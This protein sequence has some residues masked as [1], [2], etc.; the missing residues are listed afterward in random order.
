MANPIIYNRDEAGFVRHGGRIGRFEVD[1]YKYGALGEPQWFTV[2]H[3]AGARAD[4]KE[5]A[6][7]LNRAYQE[8]HVTSPTRQWGDIAYHFMMDDHGRYYRA[9]YRDAKGA[10]VSEE[11]SRNFGLMV[12]GN[13][14]THELTTAQKESLRW[15]YRGGLLVLTGEPEAG[16]KGIRTHGDW[17]ATGCPGRNLQRYMDWLRAVET[18]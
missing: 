12:H 18:L 5:T 11:N 16:F 2:H 6:V 4:D 14:D 3:A 9:R 8:M 1:T 10:H 15:L 13:Y 7:A 17:M